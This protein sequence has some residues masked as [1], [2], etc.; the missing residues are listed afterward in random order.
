MDRETE[1]DAGGGGGKKWRNGIP[2]HCVL[3]LWGLRLT[4]KTFLRAVD[5]GL[6]WHGLANR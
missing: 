4:A 5:F 3:L 1:A 6:A 2:F